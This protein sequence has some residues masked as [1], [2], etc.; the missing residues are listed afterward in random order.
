VSGSYARHIVI[1]NPCTDHAALQTMPQSP[2]STRTTRNASTRRPNVPAQIC[3]TLQTSPKRKLRSEGVCVCVCVHL[4][5]RRFVLLSA[6]SDHASLLVWSDCL[7][8][9]V[10]SKGAEEARRQPR[11]GLES[12]RCDQPG[13][14]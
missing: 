13:P 10:F 8:L 3:T 9:V 11:A 4:P 6:L 5:Y 14:R 12:S 7:T 2:S 1:T